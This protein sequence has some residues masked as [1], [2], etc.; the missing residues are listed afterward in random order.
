[1]W[2]FALGLECWVLLYNIAYV[3]D[4]IYFPRMLLGI[5]VNASIVIVT[6][7]GLEVYK[8]RYFSGFF[9]M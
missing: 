9:Y 4:E 3:I 7:L 5:I 6:F 8:S 1:V 2:I